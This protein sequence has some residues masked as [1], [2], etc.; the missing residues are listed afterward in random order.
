MRLKRLYDPNRLIRECE[1]HN[2]KALARFGIKVPKN[3][4]L[5]EQLRALSKDELID[6][7]GKLKD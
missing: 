7:I 1:A 4:G 2:A 5:V 6:I 3:D